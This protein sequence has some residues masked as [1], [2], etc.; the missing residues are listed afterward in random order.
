MAS[1]IIVL[2]MMISNTLYAVAEGYYRHR[3][4]LGGQLKE[5]SADWMLGIKMPRG[6]ETHVAVGRIAEI[7]VAEL[8]GKVCVCTGCDGVLHE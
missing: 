7:V 6:E 2:S 4:D 1:I 8:S 5:L 3:A